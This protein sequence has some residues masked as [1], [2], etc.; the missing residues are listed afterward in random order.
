MDSLKFGTSGLRGLVSALVG[1]PAFDYSLA[2]L[3]H[4]QRGGSAQARTAVLV[5]QDLRASSPRIAA[6]VMAAVRAA[7]MRPLDCGALPTPALAL[8]SMAR[9]APAIM[10]TGSH[11]P[12]DRNGLKFYRP[13]G[14]IDKQDEAGIVDAL[15]GVGETR[16]D[17]PA[18]TIDALA[19]YRDRY[20]G[21]FAG[22]LE[23]LSIAVYQ[24]SSVGRDLMVEV[25]RA[26]GGRAE[27]VGRSETFVPIDTEA[28]RPQDE[29][30]L[31]E[32]ARSGRYD[33]IV[34]TDGDADRPLVA[35]EAGRFVRGDL[36]GLL[37]AR[38]LGADV[39]V[40]PVTSNS[41]IDAVVSARVVRTLVGSPYVLAAMA[42]AAQSGARAIV[43]FEANGGVLL[44][45]SVA[46]DGRV[47]TPLPTRDA[48]L[49]ILSVL[50][51]V[52]RQARP[53]SAIVAALGA[54]EAAAHRLSEVPGALSMGLLRRLEQD[55]NWRRDFFAPAGAVADID[56]TDGLR[57]T[58][59]DGRIV[60]Y[61][62]SGNAPELRC[63]VEAADRE[64]AQALLTWGLAAAAR[65]VGRS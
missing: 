43:G 51:L 62:A 17:Q 9:G 16:A 23:G 26:C 6:E 48:L 35:D 56:T 20:A 32:L 45:S 19:A 37:T 38:S 8:A 22:A 31:A 24:H 60:H 11:I 65:Q 21:F 10:V 44:G 49:P 3:R 14:E 64:A 36:V 58:L 29:A 18:E 40:T 47:L 50:S 2:F 41:I 33:A 4:L 55:A 59:V 27:A 53:V 7:G 57:V 12:G 46:V 1:G 30:F 61:R 5:G 13:D 39:I 15:A 63:Y 34:S 52:K 42:E 28:L 54:A 25:I